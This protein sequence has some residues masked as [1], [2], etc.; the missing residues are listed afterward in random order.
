MIVRMGRGR[1]RFQFR[2][3]GNA[4][5][6]RA[7]FLTEESLHRILHLL[8]ESLFP[9][10]AVADKRVVCSVCVRARVYLLSQ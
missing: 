4:T 7:S 1:Q 6:Q 2:V 5:Q 10:L 3:S 9:R 8:A